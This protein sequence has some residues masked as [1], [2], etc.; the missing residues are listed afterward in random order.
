MTAASRKS[1]GDRAVIR[2]L[3]V[4]E[5]EE[6]IYYKDMITARQVMVVEEHMMAGR[7]VTAFK[8][9]VDLLA[10]T[11]MQEDGELI[12]EHHLA[13]ARLMDSYDPAVIDRVVEDMGINRLVR[14]YLEDLNERLA[15]KNKAE[16]ASSDKEAE[17]E[18]PLDQ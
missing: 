8:C 18:A 15:A 6:N 9:T 10:A 5:W 13:F 14:E 7:S 2:K 12:F 16:G 17:E 4:P 3:H 11:A 1:L